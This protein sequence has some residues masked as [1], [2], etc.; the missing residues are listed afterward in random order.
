M[1]TITL[2]RSLGSGVLWILSVWAIVFNYYVVVSSLRKKPNTPSIGPV[3][4]AA[5]GAV[6]LLLCP[7]V[8]PH[9]AWLPVILDPATWWLVVFVPSTCFKR[10]HHG[11]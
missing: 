1:N 8:N 6:A 2:I 4:G 11:K 5:F 3:M 10:A 9:Y 7:G